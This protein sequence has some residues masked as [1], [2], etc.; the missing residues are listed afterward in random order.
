MLSTCKFKVIYLIFIVT[1][2]LKFYTSE[3]ILLAVMFVNKYRLFLDLIFM[4]DGP[5]F[6]FDDGD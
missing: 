6:E 3:I 5:K 1:F 2:F 4:A